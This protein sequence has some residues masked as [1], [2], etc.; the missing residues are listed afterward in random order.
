LAKDVASHRP[1]LIMTSTVRMIHHFRTATSSIPIVA[2][3]SDPIAFGVA[4]SL[5]RPDGNVTGVIPDAGLEITD[6]RIALLKE[7]VPHARRLGYLAPKQAMELAVG[8]WVQKASERMNLVLVEGPL[9]SPMD[10]LEYVRVFSR[11]AKER[12][13]ALL[14]ASNAE[15]RT[16]SQ[17]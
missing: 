1:D 7:L 2:L 6:K 3:T 4:S 17:T 16:H 15:N 10:R 12:I 5:A 9:E 11:L 14:V 8:R 13:D